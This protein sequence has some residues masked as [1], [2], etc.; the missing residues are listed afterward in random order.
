MSLSL[1]EFTEA[2]REGEEMETRLNKLIG[3]DPSTS[4]HYG[5]IQ[6]YNQR[7]NSKTPDE[8]ILEIRSKYLEWKEKILQIF[9]E[10]NISLDAD[11]FN[12]LFSV[13]YM[14]GT[15]FFLGEPVDIYSSEIQPY[16]S[17]I[18][19]FLKNNKQ[20]LV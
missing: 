20:N 5:I 14:Y 3:F 18:L 15:L 6:L 8:K 11:Q 17:K 7:I 16:R 4:N 12:K 10:N 9:A 19:S 1:E 2:L 13:D